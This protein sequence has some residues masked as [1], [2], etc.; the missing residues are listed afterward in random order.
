MGH[1]LFR[2]PLP[3]TRRGR[4]KGASGL[5]GLI[6]FRD[7]EIE[8]RGRLREGYPGWAGTLR[9]RKEAPD[10]T[11]VGQGPAPYANV[12]MCIFKEAPFV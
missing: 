8:S 12:S 6:L 3:K 2:E 7:R 11:S 4:E 1:H 10:V 9:K 5:K